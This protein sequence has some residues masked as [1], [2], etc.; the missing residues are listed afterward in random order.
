MDTVDG[1]PTQARGL[2]GTRRAEAF[3]DGVFAFII[4]IG[5]AGYAVAGILG[6]L[7]TPWVASA[8]F[9]VLPIF[10]GLTSEGLDA[11]PIAASR[12]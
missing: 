2:S 7:V 6:V 11:L 1:S 12:G 3:S 8:I 5:V 4:W 9:L 10:Y